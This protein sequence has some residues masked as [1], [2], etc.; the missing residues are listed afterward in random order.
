VRAPLLRPA[1]AA[2]VLAGLASVAPAHAE[3]VEVNVTVTPH[4]GATAYAFSDKPGETFDPVS[5]QRIAVTDAGVDTA[6]GTPTVGDIA[7][8]TTGSA[9]YVITAHPAGS[10]NESFNFTAVVEC[11]LSPATGLVCTP[12]AGLH[13]VITVVTG[14]FDS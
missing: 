5:V 1:L 3:V 9:T 4:L 14:P 7:G 10:T 8:V 11:A 6:S 2:A 13:T 12:S